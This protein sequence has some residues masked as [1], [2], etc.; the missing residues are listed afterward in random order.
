MSFTHEEYHTLPIAST[1][2]LVNYITY[3]GKMVVFKLISVYFT[4]FSL[5]L[6]QVSRHISLCFYN[7]EPCIYLDGPYDPSGG[8]RDLFNYLG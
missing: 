6:K 8:F 2:I 3:V 5:L 7:P 1:G 4:Y